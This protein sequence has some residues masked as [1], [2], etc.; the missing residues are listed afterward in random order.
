MLSWQSVPLMH[1][2]IIGR[3]GT[4]PLGAVGLSTLLF[5]F[6]NL[7]FNFLTVV[8]TS[9]VANAAADG[10]TSEVRRLGRRCRMHNTGDA[11]E[12][13]QSLS[14]YGFLGPPQ[15]HGFTFA[16]R[17][18]TPGRLIARGAAGCEEGG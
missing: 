2:A 12:R 4:A 15:A 13:Q 9:A 8:T 1:A 14:W 7:F 3:L 6:S 18:Q 17:M 16:E 5:M 10:D 11:A